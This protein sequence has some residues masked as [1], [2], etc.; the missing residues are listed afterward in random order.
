LIDFD[1]T[2]YISDAATPSSRGSFPYL[3]PEIHQGQA[4]HQA[5][6]DVW[7]FGIIL[8]EIFTGKYAWGTRA[9]NEIIKFLQLGEPPKNKESIPP[10]VQEI[11]KKCLK[12]DPSERPTFDEL[13]PLL[14]EAEQESFR[15]IDGFLQ[16]YESYANV[17]NISSHGNA[18]VYRVLHPDDVKSLKKDQKIQCKVANTF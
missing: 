4:T 17:C 10:K 13:T 14:T 7:S 15:G 3:A 8:L 6:G 18:I 5:S 16:R 2:K 11:I 1:C 9:E 12:K